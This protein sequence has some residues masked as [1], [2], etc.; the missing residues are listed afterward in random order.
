MKMEIS[1]ESRQDAVFAEIKTQLR[2]LLSE[3]RLDWV[4]F[5]L[6]RAERIE[7]SPATGKKQL[8]VPFS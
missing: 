7:P 4:R 5:T 3:K 1:P 6:Q 8:I 2:K